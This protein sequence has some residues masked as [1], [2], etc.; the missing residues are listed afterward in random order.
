M[1]RCPGKIL[2]AAAERCLAIRIVSPSLEVEFLGNAGLTLPWP[3]G[4]RLSSAGAPPRKPKASF[5]C[6]C[7]NALAI[8]SIP[9]F[10]MVLWAAKP[11]HVE[12]ADGSP[13]MIPSACFV[14]EIAYEQPITAAIIS[15]KAP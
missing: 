2:L 3:G 13:L 8:R 12:T 1:A 4:R 11:R 5:N 15:Q 14:R 6:S 9:E 7:P 10:L